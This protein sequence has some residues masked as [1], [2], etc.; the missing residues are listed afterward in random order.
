MSGATL[1]HCSLC[2][3]S[4]VPKDRN[5]PIAVG[6]RTCYERPQPAS[7]SHL[8]PDSK[9]ATIA[10]SHPADADEPISANCRLSSQRSVAAMGDSQNSGHGP[11][12]VPTRI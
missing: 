1:H 3:R 11:I 9:A 8:R 5:V 10:A 2:T 6:K 7:S 4:M 12:V